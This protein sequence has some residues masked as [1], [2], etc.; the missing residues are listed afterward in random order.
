MSAPE[1]IIEK[2][3]K[4]AALARSGVGGERENARRMLEEICAKHGL[5]L[6]QIES[7]EVKECRFAYRNDFE[8]KLIYQIA[9]HV[10]GR[11]LVAY[12]YRRRGRKVKVIGVD[13]TAMQAADVETCFAHYR[14]VWA[15]QLESMMKDFFVAFVQ[16]QGLGCKQSGGGRELTPEERAQLMRAMALM[17]GMERV[18]WRRALEAR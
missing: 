9:A 12:N 10:C 16:K 3:R 18:P 1:L 14:K 8:R 6:E 15:E 13:L 7:P 4:V 2:L 5:T 11:D 17:Q